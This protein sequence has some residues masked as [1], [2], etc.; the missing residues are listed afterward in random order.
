MWKKIDNFPMYS[1]S[2]RGEV[3]NDNTGHILKPHKGARF[4]Y[5]LLTLCPGRKTVKVHR[6]VARAFIPNPENKPQVNH[7]DGDKENNSVENLEWATDS[8]NKMHRS[9]VLGFR[10]PREK[11]LEIQSLSTKALSKPVLCVETGIVYSSASE[12]ERQTGVGNPHISQC[13]HGKRKTAGGYHW[14]SYGG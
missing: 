2:D 9:R 11:M 12:A 5:M 4:G 7:K 1:V 13:L 8:E 14:Q 10:L 3:R 6:L